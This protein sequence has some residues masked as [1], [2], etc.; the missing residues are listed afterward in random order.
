MKRLKQLTSVALAILMSM[1]TLLVANAEEATT[2]NVVKTYYLYQD[3]D[4]D[5]SD[6][7]GSVSSISGATGAEVDGKYVITE[8]ATTAAISLTFTADDAI[9]EEVKVGDTVYAEMELTYPEAIDDCPYNLHL[10]YNNSTNKFKNVIAGKT[11]AAARGYL[12]AVS[13]TNDRN[14]GVYLKNLNGKTVC[15]RLT[16]TMGYWV[17]ST[18]N[19]SGSCKV[20]IWNKAKPSE[21]LEYTIKG[22]A[23][24]CGVFNQLRFTADNS[25][26]NASLFSVGNVSIWTEKEVS[27]AATVTDSESGEQSYL[28]FEEAWATVSETT[29]EVKLLAD[30]ELGDEYLTNGMTIDLNGNKLVADSLVSFN[31]NVVDNSEGKAG[32]LVCDKL[33]IPGNSQMLVWDASANGYRLATVTIEDRAVTNSTGAP[34]EFKTRPDFGAD[35]IHALVAGGRDASKVNVGIRIEWEGTNGTPYVQDCYLTTELLTKMY[36]NAESPYGATVK[37]TGTD[38]FNNITATSFVTSPLGMEKLGTA[39]APEVAE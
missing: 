35:S 33:M 14:N 19:Q 3:F 17:D 4:G 12:Y 5:T 15:I 11:A 6:D 26:A 39:H 7:T 23:L 21:K 9:K 16:M 32:L 37:L 31:A 22:Q 36:G 30:A 13:D 10:L 25:A 18:D 34:I 20:E 8:D 27:Y 28:T 38:N 1:S 29:T 2:S 24:Y